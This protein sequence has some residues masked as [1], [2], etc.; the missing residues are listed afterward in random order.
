MPLV[1]ILTYLALAIAFIAMFAKAMRYFTAPQ[2]LRWELYPVPHEKGRAEYGG[3]YLEELDWWSKPRR[4][5]TFNEIKEMMREIFLFKG[6]YHHNRKVWRFSLPFHLGLYLC[7]GWLVLLLV[8]AIME[9]AGVAVSA[10]AGIIGVAVHYLTIVFGYAGL[11]LS[12]LGALG[13]LQWRMSDTN[14]RRIRCRGGSHSDRAI[15]RRSGIRRSARLYRVAGVVF[16]R[17][18]A[19]NPVDGGNR[20]GVT[21]DYVHPLDPHVAFCRKIFSLSRGSLERPTQ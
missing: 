5:D 17:D 10:S 1:Q 6:V 12:G 20:A 15:D 11:I 8:G 21:V 7:I 13:L 18:P 9:R 14:Q 2:H 3:S 19:G 4:P 16:N